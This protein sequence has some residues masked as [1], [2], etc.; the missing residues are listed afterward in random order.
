VII[1]MVVVVVLEEMLGIK[2]VQEVGQIASL[3][4]A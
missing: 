1:K 3:G 2:L 4:Q